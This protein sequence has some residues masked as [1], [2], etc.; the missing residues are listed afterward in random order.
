MCRI[1]PTFG[2]LCSRDSARIVLF[3]GPTQSTALLLT[4][5]DTDMDNGVLFPSHLAG[6]KLIRKNCLWKRIMFMVTLLAQVY[7]DRDKFLL[8]FYLYPFGVLTLMI[9]N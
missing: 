9:L 3:G 8:R 5:T 4:Y 6:S 1:P 7:Y 2:Q